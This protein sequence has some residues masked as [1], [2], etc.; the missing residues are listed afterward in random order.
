MYCLAARGAPRKSRSNVVLTPQE[1]VRIV[2]PGG[3]RLLDSRDISPSVVGLKAVGLSALPPSWTLPFFVLSPPLVRMLLSRDVPSH[4]ESSLRDAGAVVGFRSETPILVRSSAVDESIE[5]RGSLHSSAGDFSQVLEVILRCCASLAS[6]EDAKRRAI[7]LIVQQRAEP[8]RAKGHL[9]NER[10]FV[11]EGRDWVW[12]SETPMS[13]G[14]H[15]IALRSWRGEKE[16]DPGPLGCARELSLETTLR[17]P[18][19]WAHHR[20]A[21]VHFEWAWDGT[22]LFVVQADEAQA[23]LGVNPIEASKKDANPV[24]QFVP[25]ILRRVDGVV[26]VPYEKLRN[27]MIYREMGLPT[28]TFYLL[29][30]ASTLE[31][32][33]AQDTFPEL[34][35][36]LG[37]LCARSLVIR[38]DLAGVSQE[39]RQMLPRTPEVRSATQ[40]MSFLSNTVRELVGRGVGV[41]SI[42]FL[43][44]NFIP[45]A[46][47]AWSYAEPRGRKVLIESLWGIPEGL[48]YFAHDKY[49]IDTRRVEAAGLTAAYESSFHVS[50]RIAFKRYCVAPSAN[51]DWNPVE[52]AEPFDWRP[53][54]RKGAWPGQIARLSRQL[55]DRCGHA[56]NIMWF[57]DVEQSTGLPEVIAWYHERSELQK[58]RPVRT[59]R[60]KSILD[61]EETIESEDDIARLERLVKDGASTIRYVLIRPRSE[62]LLRNKGFA[63]RIGEAAKG[64]GAV[65]ELEGGQLSHVY[66]LLARTGAQVQVVD[67]SIAE[68]ELQEFNKLVRDGMPTKISSGGEVVRVG[69]LK[70][71]QLVEALRTKL[72]EEA[73]EA[74]DAVSDDE[75][76]EELADVL[77]VV[78]SLRDRLGETK[79]QLEGRKRR[80]RES[81]GGF[82]S[83][84]VLLDTVNPPA[85]GGGAGNQS[86]LLDSTQDGVQDIGETT[87]P[88]EAVQ[89][90][91]DRRRLGGAD[92]EMVVARAPVSMRSWSAEG[93]EIKATDARG[94][95]TSLRARI[96]AR[97]DKGEIRIEVT[98]QAEPVQLNLDLGNSGP[99][100][101]LDS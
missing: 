84:L 36:D 24:P 8:L 39:E 20:Q 47:S 33:L 76:L 81:R 38:T 27:V 31:R 44:H 14:Y 16:P 34:E 87:V 43:I 11:E 29:D 54:L 35:G 59:R 63:K 10:R 45:A 79:A 28:A 48:Y 62:S 70:D 3:T 96:S 92:E 99:D 74:R 22:R 6:D 40:A 25:Q 55:A 7:A 71:E 69:R 98:V 64:L 17:I 67:S 15:R 88:P 19:Q 21:R 94:G 83:G 42:G 100:Q 77:E 75:L 57:V 26:E 53:S 13:P 1:S 46:S 97:R 58:Y 32:L 51:G 30:G 93:G 85:A 5:Q 72:V 61:R 52:I 50:R 82:D 12:E 90:S 66:Y 73:L 91:I 49:S 101:K 68:G 37:V 89:K 78:D 4:L 80:K 60:R 23:L 18:A 95:T 41:D 9:S 56:I 2:E 86:L 65:V